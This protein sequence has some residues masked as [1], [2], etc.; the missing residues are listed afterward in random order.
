MAVDA[1]AVKATSL[2]GE[3]DTIDNGIIDGIIVEI[4]LE[5]DLDVCTELTDQLC[6][7]MVAHE[8]IMRSRTGI[9]SAGPVTAESAGG[10]SRSYGSMV[11]TERNAW[12]GQ[13]WAGQKV[14]RYF[15]ILPSSPIAASTRG[16]SV[17][18]G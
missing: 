18:C 1:C 4:G 12:F 8:L 17:Y 10:V 14:L 15:R 2:K 5:L 6:K 16:G 3:F 13:T 9:G 7:F 11:L